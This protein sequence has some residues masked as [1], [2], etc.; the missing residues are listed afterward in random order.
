MSKQREIFNTAYIP[1][2]KLL[3]EGQVE[4]YEFLNKSRREVDG[5]DDRVDWN[6]LVV[7]CLI[8]L[9]NVK[10]LTFWT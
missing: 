6:A 5:V 10:L 4:D 1:V 2:D 9:R 7:S 3:L 8:A